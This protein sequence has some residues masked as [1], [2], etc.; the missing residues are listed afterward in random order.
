MID[1]I[2]KNYDMKF[3]QEA[4]VKTDR[5]P[6][7]REYDGSIYAWQCPECKLLW[8]VYQNPYHDKNC[9]FYVECEG[10]GE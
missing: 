4:K 6:L 5:I 7:R 10:G 2:I 9:S 3:E 8:K 1:E